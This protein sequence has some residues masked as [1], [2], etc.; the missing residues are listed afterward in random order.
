M[1]DA[2]IDNEESAQVFF[3]Q[4]RDSDERWFE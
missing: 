1:P 3:G 4:K 2:I